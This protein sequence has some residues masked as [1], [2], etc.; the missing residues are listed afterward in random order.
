MNGDS[1]KE[2]RVFTERRTGEH[3]DDKSVG[4][5]GL[6]SSS[7]T[8]DDANMKRGDKLYF[9]KVEDRCS[10]SI[11]VD[12]YE[13]YYTV[14]SP[15]VYEW[16]VVSV[17]PQGAWICEGG[18]PSNDDISPLHSG[19]VWRKLSTIERRW[20]RTKQEAWAHCHGRMKRWKRILEERIVRIERKIEL[21]HQ[22]AQEK[23]SA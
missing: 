19:P 16:T 11:G 13:S 15:Q 8:R 18:L 17:T 2:S 22:K 14:Q 12:G 23:T 6:D 1:R 3:I 9:A 4:N 5:Q 20:G 7:G 10:V 21:S